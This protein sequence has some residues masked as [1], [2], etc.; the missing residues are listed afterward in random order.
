[1]ANDKLALLTQSRFDFAN[2]QQQSLFDD[3]ARYKSL[4]NS[5]IEDDGTYPW[6]YQLFSPMVFSTLRSFVARIAAGN[7]GVDLQAWTEEGRPKIPVNKALLEW[8]FQEAQLFLIVARWVFAT[9]LVGRGFV[10]TG[11]FYQKERYVQEEDEEGKA[12]RKILMRPK[13]N[14]ADLQNVRSVDIFVANRN[15]PDLQKQPWI[16]HRTYKTIPELD[17]IN[18]AR[19]EEVYRNLK[20]LKEKDWFVTFV[21]QG[22]DVQKA[23]SEGDKKDRWRSGVLEILRMWDKDKGRVVET[24]RGH[25]DF[26]IREEE[27]PFYHGDYPYADLQF[28]PQDDEF[29]SPGL[30][31]PIEDLQIGLN[32]NLNQFFTNADQQL[33]NMWITSDTRIPEWEFISRPNGVIHVSGD[34]NNLK[35]VQHKDITGVAESMAGRL[36]TM[37][38]RTTGI[39][40]QLAAGTAPQGTKGAA[41]LQL[42]QQNLDDN[43]K[44]FLTILEQV[45]IKRIAQQF[46][47]NNQQFITQEQVIKISGR[48]GYRHQS[49]KPDEV[50]AAFDP[51]IIPQSVIPKNPL[52]RAQNIVQVLELAGK[53]Q[54][55]KIN[56]APVWQELIDTMGMTDLD[57]IVPSDVD[58]A[59]QENEL[60]EKNVQVECEPT[61]NHDTHIQIHQY[62]I[63][64]K[65]ITD[66]AT[67]KRFVEHIK[68]HKT[69]KLSADPEL[70]DKLATGGKPIPG[71]IENPQP[72]PA[73]SPTTNVI[74]PQ[75]PNPQLSPQTAPVDEAGLVQQ[76]GQGAALPSLLPEGGAPVASALDQIG[77][78][79]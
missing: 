53:E 17:A 18:E 65:E 54:Q 13:V 7:V 19:G 16:V 3:F 32:A 68:E 46:L 28:F 72:E 29:W 76:L 30:V 60:L 34:V 6:D 14:R 22:Y 2:G 73:K 50:S 39:T 11:W 33:N 27:N 66:A 31:Q 63:V 5:K 62:P 21:E 41:Y 4:W 23:D 48:H 57:E 35:E 52:I 59:M 77:G 44:L 26:T 1:M 8:E 64:S 38:Q 25:S 78:G 20:K 67:V 12:K 58:E 55:V 51:I 79:Y 42:E 10:E 43:L 40:D 36:E 15:I 61:D 49:I 74:M 9:G 47:A 56:K 24:V 71:Q 70:L 37:I 45:G 75:A 69:W